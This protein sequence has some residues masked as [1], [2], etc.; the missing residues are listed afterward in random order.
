MNKH[1]KETLLTMLLALLVS[2]LVAFMLAP[3]A[4]AS[5]PIPIE[6]YQTIRQTK[7]DSTLIFK[8]YP[9]KEWR[10]TDCQ[11]TNS[12]DLIAVFFF[13]RDYQVGDIYPD[14][15]FGT[16]AFTRYVTRD[17]SQLENYAIV[18]FMKGCQYHT[19]IQDGQLVKDTKGNVIKS[20]GEVVDYFFQNWVIDSQDIN[21]LYWLHAD[22]KYTKSGVMFS[23]DRDDLISYGDQKPESPSLF[24]YDLPAQS[25]WNQYA[26]WA[27]INSVAFQTCLFKKSDLP[28]ETVRTDMSFKDR[29]LV[30]FNWTNLWTWNFKTMRMNRSFKVDEVCR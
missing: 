2:A 12:C 29:A 23:D 7:G 1:Q 11:K 13:Q 16:E 30:C 18:Q 19:Y 20:F 26:N 22:Y 10:N 14:E 25:F 3:K 5:T 17:V 27:F 15:N 24:V 9:V 28:T 4:K 8:D 21:P 6:M